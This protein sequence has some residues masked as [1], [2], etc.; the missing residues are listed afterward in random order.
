MLKVKNRNFKLSENS[1]ETL[2]KK[3]TKNVP[4]KK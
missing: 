4:K 2:K 3:L 1:L